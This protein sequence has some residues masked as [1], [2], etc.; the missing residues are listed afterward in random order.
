MIAY[1]TEQADETLSELRHQLHRTN[2][3]IA[4]LEKEISAEH[5]AQLK[6]TRD[7]KEKER[8]AHSE[9]KPQQV[10]KP[11]ATQFPDQEKLVEDLEV[12]KQALSRLS[13]EAKDLEKEQGTLEKRQTS[14]ARIKE[15][16]NTLR[17][18]YQ[19][20]LSEK[21]QESQAV[22]LDLPELVRLSV[23]LGP[24]ESLIQSTTSQEQAISARLSKS[25][26]PSES[27]ALRENLTRIQ[28]TL[29]APQKK[30]EEFLK[31]MESWKQRE[32]EIIGDVETVGSVVYLDAKLARLNDEAPKQLQEL[33]EEREGL[34]RSIWGELTE[35]LETYRELYR[36]VQD[37]IQEKDFVRENLK[38]EFAVLIDSGEFRDRFLAMV[39]H[40]KRGSFYGVESGKE[41][42]DT[43][44][45]T[46]DMMDPD[47]VLGFCESLI[48]RLNYDF[49]DNK[50]ERLKIEPQLLDHVSRVE[51]YD[52]VYSL[53][54]LK[55]RYTMKLSSKEIEAL[56]PGERGILLLV[57]YLLLD[58][59]EIPLII[60]QPKQNLDNESIFNILVP[61]IREAKQRRQIFIVTHNPNLA[62]VC[63]AEQLISTSIAKDEGNRVTYRMGA[64]EDHPINVQAVNVLEGTWP[65][66]E[67]RWEKFTPSR[68]NESY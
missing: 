25:N 56:S 49:R 1:R 51:L 18:R 6:A 42:T 53:S 9:I 4:Q 67:S 26:L 30:Y 28:A 52:F 54:Y 58:R 32:K 19:R 36:P 62:M 60:D 43:L 35:L 45:A 38:L 31:S 68:V 2:T 21:S 8:K 65:A 27:T 7:L 11:T 63:D 64:I 33:Q 50:H 16:I 55:P 34:T 40:G 22:G 24:L 57:F 46:A 10:P 13:K 37:F 3:N 41:F 44:V 5:R 23:N 48:E 61:C 47:S 15:S 20:I 66:L 14:L 59:E 17:L 29:T 39:N 12:T